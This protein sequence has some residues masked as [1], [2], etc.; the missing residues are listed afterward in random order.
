VIAALVIFAL[1]FSCGALCCALWALRIADDNARMMAT[2][3]RAVLLF[4]PIVDEVHDLSTKM[5]E[6]YTGHVPLAQR[7]ADVPKVTE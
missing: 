1:L 3:V 4:W 6:C 7:N 2:C 5:A